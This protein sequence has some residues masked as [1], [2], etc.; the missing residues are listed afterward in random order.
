LFPLDCCGCA[1]RTSRINAECAFLGA[2]ARRRHWRPIVLSTRSGSALTWRRVTWRRVEP[3]AARWRFELACT[4]EEARGRRD[5]EQRSGGGARSLGSETVSELASAGA[6]IEVATIEVA[7]GALASWNK[8]ARMP[9]IVI[10][11][12]SARGQADRTKCQPL[13][14]ISDSQL[15]NWAAAVLTGNK[16]S[17]G[18]LKPAFVVR[19]LKILASL[20]SRATAVAHQSSIRRWF[21]SSAGIESVLV[22]LSRSAINSWSRL[23]RNQASKNSARSWRSSNLR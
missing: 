18:K 23:S 11:A 17:E 6:T 4:L 15:W 20:E 3:P 2:A 7:T 9:A 19:W 13:E 14:A 5:G 21:S 16:R 12:C 1:S 8:S 10:T 22:P